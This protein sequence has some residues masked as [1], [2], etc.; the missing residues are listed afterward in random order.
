M[1]SIRQVAISEPLVDVVDRGQV[2][3]NNELIKVAIRY[4]PLGKNIFF[5]EIDLYT[6]K[7]SDLTFEVPF[8]LRIIRNDYVQALV[9]FFT[10]EFSKCHKRIGF[11]T[12]PDCKYT[13]WHF[14]PIS[15]S[16]RWLGSSWRCIKVMIQITRQKNNLN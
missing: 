15:L 13:V 4:L 9:T 6:V 16:V 1:S 2:V 12:A 10:V 14:L 11:S 3:T 5:Q 8:T 7:V